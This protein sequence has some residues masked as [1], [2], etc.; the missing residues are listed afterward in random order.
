M[1]AKSRSVASLPRNNVSGSDTWSVRARVTLHSATSNG[2]RRV[3]GQRVVDHSA[4]DERCRVLV[5]GFCESSNAFLVYLQD[6]PFV[7]YSVQPRRAAT[8]HNSRAQRCAHGKRIIVRATGVQAESL[9]QAS[10]KKHMLAMPRQVWLMG[11]LQRHGE[12]HAAHVEQ[13]PLAPA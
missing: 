1:T 7:R 2:P 5:R 8:Q 4:A 11:I 6:V 12:R 3:S 13:A 9:A 10:A